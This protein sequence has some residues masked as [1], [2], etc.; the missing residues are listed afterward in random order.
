[1]DSR[2]AAYRIALTVR[3]E[4][5]AWTGRSDRA[6]QTSSATRRATM[7]TRRAGTPR[8]V[9]TLSLIHISEPTR[10]Y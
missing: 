4:L 3:S 9:P 5:A 7:T 2:P 8:T 6:D 10:P 1:M